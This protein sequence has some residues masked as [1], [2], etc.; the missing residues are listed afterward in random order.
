MD[1]SEIA[2]KLTEL[3]NLLD[4]SG[5]NSF[6]VR[7]YRWAV[8]AIESSTLVFERMVRDGQRLTNIDG[9][10]KSIGDKIVEIVRTGTCAALE[11][12]RQAVNPDL[13]ELLKLEGLG[14]KKVKK[15]LK[16]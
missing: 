8:R 7:S 13:I 10:G 4:I 12:A 1:N 14:P 15:L 2:D 11:E 16:I 9:I 6:R 3:A 5:E